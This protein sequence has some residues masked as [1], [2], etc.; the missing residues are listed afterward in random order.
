MRRSD[1]R[2]PGH[3]NALLKKPKPKPPTTFEIVFSPSGEV[4]GFKHNPQERE[5]K[6]PE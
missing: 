5:E 3:Y 2:P 6:E 1:E 4:V